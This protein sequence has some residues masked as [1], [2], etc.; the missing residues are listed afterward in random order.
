[1][2]LFTIYTE[3]RPNLA[4]LTSGRFEGFTLV[5]AEGYWRGL[6]EDSTKIE[7]LADAER[8]AD[9]LTLAEEIRFVNEQQ[10]VFVTEADVRAELVIAAVTEL[11]IVKDAV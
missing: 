9:V 10:A 7:I 2:K 6:R 3:S 8:R 5:K 1:M 4:R 11:P